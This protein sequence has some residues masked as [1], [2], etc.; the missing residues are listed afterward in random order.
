M[1]ISA[2]VTSYAACFI[3]KFLNLPNNECYY[4]D[5]D[6]AVLEK[7]LDPKYVGDELGQFKYLGKIKRGY[8]IGP[9]LYCIVFE[10]EKKII[11]YKGIDNIELVENDFINMLYGLNIEKKDIFRFKNDFSNLTINYN[12]SKY[13]ISPNMLKRKAI[14][15]NI[16][17]IDT[18]PL[19]V[20]D[21]KLMLNNIIK[22]NYSLVKYNP[23]KYA[24]IKYN[25]K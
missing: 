11:K 3:H 1:P 8:F 13:I 22:L 4:S 14:Y 6:Y 16:I 20:I 12:K 5:T 15:K 21:G 18:K 17:I 7:E 10:Y 2:M 19:C 25:S 9:K 23:S 24:L